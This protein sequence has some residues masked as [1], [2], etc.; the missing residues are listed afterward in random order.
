MN[1]RTALFSSMFLGALLPRSLH[2]QGQGRRLAVRDRDKAAELRPVDPPADDAEPAGADSDQIP[3]QAG[4][5]FKSWDI[6]GY[7][8]IREH[9]A[10]PEKALIDWIFLRTAPSDWHGDRLAA[11][12]ADR[13]KLY[14]Y[15]S[16][17]ILKQVNDIVQRFT[18]S[19]EDILSVNVRIVAAVDPRWRYTVYWHLTYVGGGPQGQQIW[20]MKM[21]DAAL[22]LSQMSIQQGFRTLARG[23][24]EMI[25]GQTVKWKTQEERTFVGGL[26]RDSSAGI[27]FQPRP[28]KLNEG[29]V[30]KLSPLLTFNGDGVNAKIDLTVN[31]LRTLH[32]TRVIAPREIGAGG[33]TTIEVPE[34]TETH[35][36]QTVKNWPL[37]QTLV[38]SCGIQPGILDKKSGLFNLPIPGTFPTATEVLVFLDVVKAERRRAPVRDPEPPAPRRSPT[39]RATKPIPNRSTPIPSRRPVI[40]APDCMVWPD[41]CPATLGFSPILRS[42]EM[43]VGECR[44]KDCLRALPVA[45]YN[46]NGQSLDAS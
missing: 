39:P 12:W 11:L 20:T 22:V 41:D 28:E 6:S 40:I 29:V 46:R 34:A 44:K 43:F 23:S 27:S 42:G 8:G 15:N 18:A 31:T 9:K 14:A 19:V 4:F 7:T 33:E 17:E 30:L 37:G 1:R 26:Q 3:L 35:L 10:P 5:K 21:Q 38:I 16:P 45:Q 13:S 24:L 25:N 2:A 32:R 36:E